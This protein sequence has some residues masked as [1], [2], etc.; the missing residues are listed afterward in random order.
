M[1]LVVISYNLLAARHLLPERYPDSPRDLLESGHRFRRAA[2]QV[3]SSG[4]DCVCLQEVEPASFEILSRQLGRLGYQG[5]QDHRS[6]S[7]DEGCALFVHPSRVRLLALSRCDFVDDEEL[8]GASHRFA[9]LGDVES[10]GTRFLL[11]NTHLQWDPPDAPAGRRRGEAQARQLIAEI[12][13]RNGPTG[14]AIVCGDFNAGPHHPVFRLFIDS[15]FRAARPGDGETP[16][17]RANGRLSE[18]DFIFHRGFPT[19]H[20][21]PRARLDV[22]MPM[23]GS[24]HPS[25]HLPIGAAFEG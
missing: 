2:A 14:A 22:S 18:V 15:G 5:H 11:A 13:R 17:C 6:P 25:D 20:P 1:S 23:P 24:D 4:A 3:A 8:G 21:L 10:D 19:V 12:N 9:Q 7:M 16:T